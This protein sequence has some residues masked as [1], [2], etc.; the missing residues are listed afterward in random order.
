MPMIAKLPCFI[1]LLLRY[2]FFY[3]TLLIQISLSIFCW[4]FSRYSKSTNSIPIKKKKY[5]SVLPSAFH[6]RCQPRHRFCPSLHQ[7]RF[8]GQRFLTRHSEQVWI[9][10]QVGAMSVLSF[11]IP[12]VES[13]PISARAV[14]GAGNG[15]IFFARVSVYQHAQHFQRQ[16]HFPARMSLLDGRGRRRVKSGNHHEGRGDDDDDDDD[17]DVEASG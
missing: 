7:R 16:N 6:R 3:L 13:S 1:I 17:D 4:I 9:Y 12:T 5:A 2:T 15:S 11:S 14:L 10:I 8:V